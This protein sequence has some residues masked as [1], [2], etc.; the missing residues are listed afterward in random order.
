MWR[1]EKPS[2][3]DTSE[4]PLGHVPPQ[5]PG[6]LP[7]RTHSKLGPN[8]NLQVCRC[9]LVFCDHFLCGKYDPAGARC[10][11]QGGEAFGMRSAVEGVYEAWCSRLGHVHLQKRSDSRGYWVLCQYLPLA[12][13]HRCHGTWD[14][15][16]GS[17]PVL[18]R[19]LEHVGE[20]APVLEG[21]APVLESGGWST[22][23][24]AHRYLRVV[25]PEH[26]GERGLSKARGR[27]RTGT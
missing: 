17:A 27:E 7:P 1:L 6:S 3:P 9:V 15:A 20:S 19:G 2:R 12:K 25:C 21:G 10:S 11:W 5:R 18:E 13:L 8:L 26:V 23:A 22:W 14:A 16:G 4:Q 24:R